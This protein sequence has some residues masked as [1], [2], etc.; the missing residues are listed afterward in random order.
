MGAFPAAITPMQG[1]SGTGYVAVLSAFGPNYFG[2]GSTYFD[3]DDNALSGVDVVAP[4]G[5]DTFIAASNLLNL[6]IQAAPDWIGYS[7]Q[8]KSL[9]VLGPSGDEIQV[10]P[11]EGF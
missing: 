9:Y 2:A 10:I 4:N 7:Q 1:A 8:T 11:A 3:G 6:M 5:S